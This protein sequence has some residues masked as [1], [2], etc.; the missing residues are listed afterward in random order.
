LI[1]T[2]LVWLVLTQTAQKTGQ[3]EIL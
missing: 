1:S 2:H 3:K